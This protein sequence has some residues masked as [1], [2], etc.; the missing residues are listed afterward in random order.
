[1][2]SFGTWIRSKVLKEKINADLDQDTQNLIENE[3]NEMGEN[4]YNDGYNITYHPS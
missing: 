4:L 1:F 2:T 3:L